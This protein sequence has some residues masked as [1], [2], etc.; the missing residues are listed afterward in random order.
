MTIALNLSNDWRVINDPVTVLY[1]VKTAEGVWA[2]GVSVPFAQR[3]AIDKRDARTAPALLEKD[4][5]EF[6]LWTARLS[7]IV[8]KIGDRITD[9]AAVLWLVREVQ[10]MDRDA[11]GVQR[12]RCTC[13][14][15]TAT[16]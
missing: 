4:G 5:T 6:H 10:P 2:A 3:N 11:T 8:P 16:S 12:Y 13:I 1:A 14:K 15:S 9:A 7:G